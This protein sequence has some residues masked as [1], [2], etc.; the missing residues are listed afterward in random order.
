MGMIGLPV[1]PSVSC[2]W[3]AKLH[4]VHFVARTELGKPLNDKCPDFI[5][6]IHSWVALVDLV[7][8]T[9]SP[10]SRIWTGFI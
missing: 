3:C 8:Y 10:H 6:N 4:T 5:G 1:V 2:R 9:S 7:R